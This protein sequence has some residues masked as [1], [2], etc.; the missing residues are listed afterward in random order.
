MKRRYT[1][2]LE[3]N[4]GGVYTVTV[5]LLPGCVTQGAT[6]DEALAHVRE[7]I[8]GY[9]EI[10]QRDGEDVPEEESSF[11]LAAAEVEIVGQRRRHAHA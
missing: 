9:I 2:L 10:L 5:P 6:I 8:E 11:Q 1:V 4:P 3:E 7:A